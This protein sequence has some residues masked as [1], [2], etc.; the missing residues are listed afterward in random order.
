MVLCA[1]DH[2][3]MFYVCHQNHVLSRSGKNAAFDLRA[4]N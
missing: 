4:L 1:K 3:L 2:F